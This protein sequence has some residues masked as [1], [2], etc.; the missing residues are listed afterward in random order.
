MMKRRGFLKLLLSLP[1]VRPI[2]TWLAPAA[3]IAAPVAPV[4]ATG[5]ADVSKLASVLKV[6]YGC[7]PVFLPI[8]GGWQF[9]M[10]RCR[11]RRLEC[12]AKLMAARKRRDAWEVG[13]HQD[14]LVSIDEDLHQKPYGHAFF[15]KLNLQPDS[16]GAPLPI[17]VV[18]R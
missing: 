11:E 5:F 4:A 2:A 10:Q 16:Q 3:T 8:S 17:P 13:V 9:Y 1:F 15:G 12:S 18:I 7:L 6:Y 14:H